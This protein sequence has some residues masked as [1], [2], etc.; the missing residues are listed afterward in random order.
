M[1]MAIRWSL[2]DGSLFDTGGSVMR[3][4]LGTKVTGKGTAAIFTASRLWQSWHEPAKCQ[5][6]CVLPRPVLGK[7]RGG[8]FHGPTPLLLRHSVEI[9]S[10]LQRRAQSLSGVEVSRYTCKSGWLCQRAS[11]KLP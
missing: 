10:V 11:T 7:C 3:Q 2:G 6:W 9:I 8:G 1:G 4:N 5:G